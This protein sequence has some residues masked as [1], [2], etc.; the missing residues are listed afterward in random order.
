MRRLT[1]SDVLYTIA[2]SGRSSCSGVK[3]FIPNRRN[4]G[5]SRIDEGGPASAWNPFVLEAYTQLAAEME[6]AKGLVPQELLDAAE[7]VNSGKRQPTSLAEAR[8]FILV[9]YRSKVAGSQRAEAKQREKLQQLA[10]T[11]RR[12]VE[13]E[14]AA[15]THATDQL[16]TETWARLSQSSQPAARSG[17]SLRELC[18]RTGRPRGML[19]TEGICSTLLIELLTATEPPPPEAEAEPQNPGA[20][21]TKPKARRKN[22][23]EK[24]LVK[25]RRRRMVVFERDVWPCCRDAGW[26]HENLAAAVRAIGRDA[27]PRIDMSATHVPWKDM[28]RYFQEYL[29]FLTIKEGVS[30]PKHRT[31]SVE[32]YAN[33]LP[34]WI[35]VATLSL[36][37]CS[38]KH[39]I[40]GLQ[41]LSAVDLDRIHRAPARAHPTD[42][43][44]VKAHADRIHDFIRGAREA[45]LNAIGLANRD[46]QD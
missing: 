17:R 14:C 40:A 19:L 37:G 46:E 44:P 43:P 3:V 28:T 34:C 6:R 1:T 26:N 4:D 32:A 16:F 20:D 8:S 7:E 30:R 41:L 9:R 39:G 33:F 36:V 29:R 18:M 15:E 21:A 31:W 10:G 24:A 45:G 22:R 13:E 12:H 23:D 25:T 38:T 5:G 35:D 2:P 42:H 11:T 27:W